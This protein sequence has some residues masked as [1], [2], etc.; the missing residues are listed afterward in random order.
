MMLASKM[1]LEWLGEKYEDEVCLDAA[2]AVEIGTLEALRK[3]L[4]IPDFGGTLT[5][6][7]MGEAIAEEVKIRGKLS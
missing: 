2:R 1:M 5:T 6:L 7:E 4:T 3:G